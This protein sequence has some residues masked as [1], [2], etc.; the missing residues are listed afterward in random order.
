VCG[1]DARIRLPAA[2]VIAHTAD[3]IPYAQ[4]EIALLFK[5]KA[6]REKDEADFERVLP[7]LALRQRQWLAHALRLIHPQHRWLSE[8]N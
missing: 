8:L 2:R 1:R 5:A 6:P 3:G 7:L 4:P